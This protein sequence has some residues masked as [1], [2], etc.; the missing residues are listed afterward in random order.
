[1]GAD[2][3]IER[4]VLFDGVCNLCNASVRFIIRHDKKQKFKFASLQS[5]VSKTLIMDN[6]GE[7]LKTIVLV[8]G[9]NIYCRSNAALE[10]ARELDGL[11]PM[12]YALKIVPLF[13]RDFVYDVISRN[14]YRWFGKMDKCPLPSPEISARFIG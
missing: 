5:A 14:R 1:M 2:N 3:S 8:K 4:I 9:M 6:A 13:V 12:F 7:T 10:I 11:W